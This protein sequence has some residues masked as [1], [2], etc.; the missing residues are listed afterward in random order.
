[1]TGCDAKVTLLH[2][3]RWALTVERCGGRHSESGCILRA[4]WR[5]DI[6]VPH[7]K[8]MIRIGVL[9]CKVVPSMIL[10]SVFASRPSLTFVK[11]RVPTVGS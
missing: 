5:C 2:L 3:R 11:I 6:Y 10:T 4:I 7:E 1:M 9:T 8:C